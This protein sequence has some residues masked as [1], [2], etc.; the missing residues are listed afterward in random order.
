MFGLTAVLSSKQLLGR[1]ILPNS[2]ELT[3]AFKPCIRCRNY[4]G[5]TGRST[6]IGAEPVGA[7]ELRWPPRA[8]HASSEQSGCSCWAVS[9]SLNKFGTEGALAGETCTR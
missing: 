6:Y 4:F 2:T 7:F 1:R 8:V 3:V 5:I 9:T